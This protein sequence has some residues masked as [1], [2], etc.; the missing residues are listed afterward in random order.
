[1]VIKIDITESIRP[2]EVFSIIYVFVGGIVGFIT[3]VYNVYIFCF[4][5]FAP[6]LYVIQELSDLIKNV[7]G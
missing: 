1:M 3:T 7:G 6:R 4:V 5:M 2:T